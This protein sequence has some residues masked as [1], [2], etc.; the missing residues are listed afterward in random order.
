MGGKKRAILRD[1]QAELDELRRENEKL[2]SLVE[3]YRK[4]N[5]SQLARLIDQD[6]LE[7]YV[8]ELKAK[9]KRYE[10]NE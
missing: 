5:A 3:T 9:L 4:T 7:T 2:R 8:K 6:L 10:G 1:N